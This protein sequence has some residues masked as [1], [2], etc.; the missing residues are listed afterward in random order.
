M[1]TGG[2][3]RFSHTGAL[4]IE[5]GLTF[6]TRVR[7]QEIRE[8][9]LLQRKFFPSPYFDELKCHGEQNEMRIPYQ[10]D[11]TFP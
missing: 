10:P 6:M 1:R 9:S 7:E 4:R 5:M 8:L 3:P 2:I 11:S